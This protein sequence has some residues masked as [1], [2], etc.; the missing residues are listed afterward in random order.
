MREPGSQL[1]SKLRSEEMDSRGGT[2]NSVCFAIIYSEAYP[3]SA[4]NEPKIFN[5]K[6]ETLYHFWF[7]RTWTICTVHV[8]KMQMQQVP[9]TPDHPQLWWEKGSQSRPYWKYVVTWND[10]SP[11]YEAYK[12]NDSYTNPQI[13][14]KTKQK[15][16]PKA[17][18]RPLFTMN[19]S[20][21]KF[22]LQLKLAGHFAVLSTESCIYSTSVLY[23]TLLPLCSDKKEKGLC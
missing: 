2:W 12:D 9:T 20:V 10:T 23:S 18:H 4:H 15:K 22:S 8:I 17:R 6:N 13:K 16:P 21:H 5:L 11:F 7:L 19:K 14:N 1:R 3:S